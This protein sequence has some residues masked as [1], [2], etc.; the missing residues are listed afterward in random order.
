MLDDS[1]TTSIAELDISG[2]EKEQ[3][4]EVVERGLSHQE[5][6]RLIGQGEKMTDFLNRLNTV[7]NKKRDYLIGTDDAPSLDQLLEE[8]DQLLRE[9][10]PKE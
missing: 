8:E 7:I 10:Q 9:L 6:A 5:R 4:A 3:L 2:E 1:L